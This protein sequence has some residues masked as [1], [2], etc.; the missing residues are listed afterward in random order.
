MTTSSKSFIVYQNILSDIQN[1]SFAFLTLRWESKKYDQWQAE[2]VTFFCSSLINNLS[3]VYFNAV[4]KMW[5][6]DVNYSL[7]QWCMFGKRL[8]NMLPLILSIICK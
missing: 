7:L 3:H 5:I 2:H 4:R 8:L 1:I 6:N